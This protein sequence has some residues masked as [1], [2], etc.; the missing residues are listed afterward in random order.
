H[1]DRLIEQH[2]ARGETLAEARRAAFAAMDGLEQRKEECRDTRRVRFADELRQDLRYAGRQF[3]K[4]P[5]FTVVV[6]LVLALAIAGNTAIFSLVHTVFSP[7]AIPNADRTVMVWTESP[8][9]NW[10]QFPASMPDFRDWQASGVFSSLAAFEEEGFNVRLHDR[11]ERV[12]GLRTTTG[13]FETLSISPARGRVFAARDVS[14]EHVALVSD[15]VWRG[16]F[17]GNPNLI[18]ASV[19]LDGTPHTI[20][21]VLPPNFPRFG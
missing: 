11:T 20:I 16:T 13:F 7:L 14:T 9:R 6:T 2:L 18:G 15:R 4:N 19:V 3:R 10:H 1:V 12:E 17:E 21:G 8:A 5:G